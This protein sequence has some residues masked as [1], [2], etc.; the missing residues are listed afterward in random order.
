[1]NLWDSYIWDLGSQPA[2][3]EPWEILLGV[4]VPNLNLNLWIVQVRIWGIRKK[5]EC[6]REQGKTVGSLREKDFGGGINIPAPALRP[7]ACRVENGSNLEGVPGWDDGPQRSWG[8]LPPRLNGGE[9]CSCIDLWR[10]KCPVSLDLKQGTKSSL[11][12]S[13]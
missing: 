4:C 11:N 5:G 1:M 13:F 6:F 8:V 2:L 7:P 9:L 3:V 12:L 10:N